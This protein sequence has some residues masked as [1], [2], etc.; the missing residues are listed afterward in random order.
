[1]RVS[2]NL[3]GDKELAAAFVE[4]STNFRGGKI[5]RAAL[6]ASSVIRDEARNNI[7]GPDWI[8]PKD[9]KQVARRTGNLKR[10]ITV[11]LEV[12]QRGYAVATVVAQAAYAAFVEFGTSRMA[13]RSYLRKAI[14]EHKDDAARAMREKIIDIFGE[15]KGIRKR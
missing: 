5:G 15:T 9:P 11:I 6:A 7:F 10:S 14:R 8:P 2:V 13:A 12:S 4:L 1:M 3:K